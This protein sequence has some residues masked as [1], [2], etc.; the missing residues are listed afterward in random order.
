MRIKYGVA[1][2]LLYLLTGLS[3]NYLTIFFMKLSGIRLKRAC[4]FVRLK[5]GV[6][7]SSV[8]VLGIRENFQLDF[9]EIN[10]L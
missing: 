2:S 6:V 10:I 3:E 7:S 4:D 1:S 8:Y 5:Y 9:Y